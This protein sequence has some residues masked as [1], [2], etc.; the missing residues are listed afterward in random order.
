M[1]STFKVLC[2]ISNFL[3][4]RRLQALK[5]GIGNGLETTQ[6]HRFALI[7]IF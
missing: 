6:L 3:I 2:L 7:F 4:M 5:I 1:R